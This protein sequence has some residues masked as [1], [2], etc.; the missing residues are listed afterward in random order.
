MSRILGIDYGTVRTGI[1]ITDEL[2]ITAQ[3]LETITTNGSDKMLLKRLEEIIN[4]YSVDCLV[5]GNPI[6]MD[7]TKGKRAEETE[8]FL[9]KLKSRFNKLK[10]V[11]IDERLT[12]VEAHKTMNFLDINNKKKKQVVDTIAAVYI[13]EGYIN[14]KAWF[15]SSFGVK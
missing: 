4:E 13:L 10:I 9:H 8:L 6:N 12:S 11:Q 14:K 2:G 7:G 1:A 5:L 3:G 15:L